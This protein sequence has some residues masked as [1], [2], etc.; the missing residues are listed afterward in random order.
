MN[1]SRYSY[2]G[3]L[4]EGSFGTVLKAH[5]K[6]N[7]AVVGIKII[8]AKKSIVEFLCLRCQLPVNKGEGR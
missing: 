5:D 2:D 6:L 1:G 4:G 8:K 3:V 7:D